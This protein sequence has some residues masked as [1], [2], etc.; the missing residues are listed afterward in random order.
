MKRTIGA[1]GI[2]AAFGL[3]CNLSGAA[4]ALLAH[5]QRRAGWLAVASLLVG[6][7]TWILLLV[8]GGEE[9]QSGD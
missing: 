2:M 8:W 5:D 9:V 7:V 3:C 4:L 6:A 1:I